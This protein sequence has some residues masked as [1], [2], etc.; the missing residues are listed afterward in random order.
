[1]N[2][3]K[4]ELMHYGVLGMKWGVVHTKPKNSI[5]DYY[6]DRKKNRMTKT[7]VRVLRKDIKE[8]ESNAAIFNKAASNNYKKAD[9]H[10]WTSERAQNRGDM[11]KYEKYQG[12]AWKQLAKQYENLQKAERFTKEANA[13][14]KRMSDITS[15]KLKAGRDFVT[16]RIYSTSLPLDMIGVVNLSM[17]QKLTLK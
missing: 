3:K 2:E 4:N 13:S 6:S 9:K 8:N 1:M 15:G 12:K 14:K 17:D 5:G 7:A 11:K 16:N 10:V